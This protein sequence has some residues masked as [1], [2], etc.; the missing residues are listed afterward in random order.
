MVH[1]LAAPLQHQTADLPRWYKIMSSQGIVN[2]S[3][4]DGLLSSIDGVTNPLM[5]KWQKNKGDFE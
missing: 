3:H 4:V 1:K 5:C 2:V